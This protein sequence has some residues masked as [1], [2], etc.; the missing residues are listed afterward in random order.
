[1]PFDAM[2][3]RGLELMPPDCEQGCIT[4]MHLMRWEALP[5]C[6]IVAERC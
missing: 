6:W 3:I 5:M 4:I 2:H 1:M